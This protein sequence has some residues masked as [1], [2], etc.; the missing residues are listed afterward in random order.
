ML[1]AFDVDAI[2]A[3]K[4]LQ[5]LCTVRCVFSSCINFHKLILRFAVNHLSQRQQILCCASKFFV[6]WPNW[7]S[8]KIESYMILFSKALRG[9]KYFF[10]LFTKLK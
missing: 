1:V 8:K 5:V 9:S 10:F 4:I 3:C 2:C 7:V 6:Y